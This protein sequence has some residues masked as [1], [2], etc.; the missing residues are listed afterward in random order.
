M[1]QIA[2]VSEKAVIHAQ[3][4]YVLEKI[5]DLG[6]AEDVVAVAAPLCADPYSFTT[7]KYGFFKYRK[8]VDK[9]VRPLK[10]LCLS[11]HLDSCTL[12]SAG[13]C[14]TT[15]NAKLLNASRVN[16]S[17]ERTACSKLCTGDHM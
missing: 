1:E 4:N 8:L 10:G 3:G 9:L 5:L 6:D 17:R 16:A 2:A 7:V 14:F 13:L 11:P 15:K 12:L